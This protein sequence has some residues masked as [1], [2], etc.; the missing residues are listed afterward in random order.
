MNKDKQAKWLKKLRHF[1]RDLKEVVIG[2]DLDFQT[3][4]LGKLLDDMETE[5]HGGGTGTD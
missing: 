1:E 5:I 4:R 3:E 2:A